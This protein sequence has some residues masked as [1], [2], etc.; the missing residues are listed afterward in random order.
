[1]IKV[2]SNLE[3]I[4]RLVLAAIIG[5]LIG[6][7]R[8]ISNRPAGLRT[9]I[10]VTTG[11]CLIMLVSIDG[12]FILGEGVLSG[13]PAR[14]AAQVVSGIGFIG[15]GT[16]LR[17]GNNIT[18]LTT[19]ASL[20]VSAGIGLA[21]GAGYYLGAIVTAAIVLLTLMSL[22]VFDRRRLMR[23]YKRI[24]VIGVD[25]PGLIGNIG[26]LFAKHNINI[27]DIKIIGNELHDTED[28]GMVRVMFV[29]KMPNNF[30][31][32]NLELEIQELPGIVGVSFNNNIY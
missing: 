12:F 23:R 5:G 26:T 3:I 1:M 28:V 6:T 30:N 31:K 18:G 32:E 17:T 9:H 7:E 22:R 20:W 8:E 13:D 16:I 10:L 27:K 25:K 19:A 4:T 15:A 24:E 29:V 2:I 14:L 11:A 21:I